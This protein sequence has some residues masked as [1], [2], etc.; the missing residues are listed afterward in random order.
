MN[1]TERVKELI[2]SGSY[3]LDREAACR[4]I[5]LSL[6]AG[7][8]VFLYG[9]PGTA[10]TLMAK[11]AASLLDTKKI[12]SCLLNQYTQP[13]ELFGPV[14]IKSLEN[15]TRELLTQGYMPEAEISFLDE[16]WK[17]GPAILNTLLTLCNEKTF[18]N[19]ANVMKV[20]LKLL[21]SAANEF[22]GEDSGL[23]PLYDRFLVRLIVNPVARKDSF[24]KLVTE[25]SLS[26]VSLGVAPISAEELDGWKSGSQLVDVPKEITNFLFSLRLRLMENDVYVSDRRWKKIVKLLRTSAYLNGRSRVGYSDLFLLE[27]VLWSKIEEIPVVVECVLSSISVDT[28]KGSFSFTDR[29]SGVIE[30]LRTGNDSGVRYDEL[31]AKIDSESSYLDSLKMELESAK[32][33][34]AGFW[35]NVFSGLS[36]EFERLMMDKGVEM[37]REFISHAEEE[38]ENI[39]FSRQPRVRE[40]FDSIGKD[41]VAPTVILQQRKKTVEESPRA[42][43]PAEEDAAENAVPENPRPEKEYGSEEESYRMSLS[44]VKSF[45]EFVEMSKFDYTGDSSDRRYKWND[46]SNNGEKWWNIGSRFYHLLDGDRNVLSAIEDECAKRGAS[47]GGKYQWVFAVCYIFEKNDGKF[48]WKTRAELEWLTGNAWKHLEPVL[49]E[50]L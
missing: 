15:G 45:E 7:E 32:T 24:V 43:V 12:F 9:R 27:N 41:G 16:I 39:R 4:M 3:L 44:R 42:D 2:E 48:D 10:K 11:W 49:S 38:L 40:V 18:R 50:A 19:G 20:P 37:L 47:V 17:A 21:I 5:V 25:R 26:D 29:I 36:S 33:G 34:S 31:S 14:S 22:P 8:S 46:N 30:K 13:D 1:M 23:E 28:V 6:A 35:R